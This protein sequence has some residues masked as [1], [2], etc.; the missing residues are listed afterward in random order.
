MKKLGYGIDA[1]GKPYVL[2]KKAAK[3]AKAKQVSGP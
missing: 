2:P 3:K 1:D